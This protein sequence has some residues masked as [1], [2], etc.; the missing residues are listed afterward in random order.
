MPAGARRYAFFLCESPLATRSTAARLEAAVVCEQP[1]SPHPGPLVMR[2]DPI[3]PACPPPVAFA[4]I[5]SCRRRFLRCLLRRKAHA[6]RV[7]SCGSSFA[8]AMRARMAKSLTCVCW[9]V[10]MRLFPLA[11]Q[12]A[13]D[14]TVCNCPE[15]WYQPRH[16]TPSKSSGNPHLA[17]SSSPRSRVPHSN[18]SG[19]LRWSRSA[20][21]LARGLP[22]NRRRTAGPPSD[23]GA[24]GDAE[25]GPA[26]PR[27]VHLD[28]HC[29]R[30]PGKLDTHARTHA[31]RS[32]LATRTHSLGRMNGHR[33]WQRP[34]AIRRW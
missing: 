24:F 3:D 33:N 4:A 9:R 21:S 5:V 15:S 29:Q 31:H 30:G 13:I 20:I 34:W 6:G 27:T 19:R 26:A 18:M 25:Q 23:E 12:V 10:E 16:G 28:Q 1:P 7:S 14:R 32:L 2:F 17:T 11:P 8:V 22:A